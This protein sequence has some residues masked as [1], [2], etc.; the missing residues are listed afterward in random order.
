M[1]PDGNEISYPFPDVCVHELFERQVAR[2]PDAVAIV[3]KQRSLTYG[4][5]NQR[6][7]RVAHFL[8]ARGIGPEILVGVCQERTPELVVALLA[9]WKAGGAY[10]PFD[11]SYPRERLLFM[12][13]DA[14]VEFLLT[15]ETCAKLLPF[16]SDKAVRL[17]SD[18]PLFA[19]EKTSDPGAT[20]KSCNLAYVMYTSGSTGQPK[21]VMILH[22]GLVNYL[23][24]A[25]GAHGVSGSVPVHSSIAF[26]STVAS[27]YPPLLTGGQIELISDD[28][29]VQGLL[30]ALRKEKFRGKLVLTPAH[31]ELLT[32]QLAPNELAGIARALVIAGESLLAEKLSSWKDFAP[33]TRLINEYGPTEATVGCCAYEVQSTDP[34]HGPVP[35]GR[36]I[37]NTQIYLL[38]DNLQQ[39]PRGVAGEMY[40]GGAG[41]AR[42]YWNRPELTKER[43]PDDQF[44]GRA[45][46]RLYKT[47]DLARRL[48]DGTL[49]FIGRV[50]DQVKVRG[51][52]IE[53]GEIEATLARHPGV[54]SCAVVAREDVPGNKQLV[55]YAIATEPGSLTSEDLQ[56]FLGQR[57]P[58]FMVPS[59]FVI[60]D[61]FPVT[62]NGKIERKAL[63]APVY[64]DALP[65]GGLVPPRNEIEEK[66][67]AIWR[68]LLK[69]DRIG[70][71]DDFFDLG[72]H[73]LL[74]IGATARIQKSFGVDLQ[75]QTLFQHP[76]IAKL[77]KMIAETENSDIASTD[78]E[79]K[80]TY[81]LDVQAAGDEPPFFCVGAGVLLRPLSGA[82]GSNQ[83][84]HSIGIEPTAIAK[85]EPPYR[86]EELARHLVS[87][88]RGK[89]PQGPYYLGGFCLDGV[90]AYEIARQ[91]RAQG[92]QVALL[93]LL[94][95]ENPLANFRVRVETGLKRLF[96]R[97]QFRIN[98]FLRTGIHEIPNYFRSRRKEFD[99]FLSR[100]R[101]RLGVRFG[102][103]RSIPEQPDMEKILYLATISYVPA[104]LDCPTVLFRG[105]DWPI[106]SAGDPY[107]G[108][109]ELLA[110]P[111]ET[112]EV[113]G[114]HIGIFSG[115]N[116][117][118]LAC[119]LRDCLQRA[120]LRAASGRPSET[121]ASVA[122]GM[123]V[124]WA[125]HGR[126]M[127][128]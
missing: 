105:E 34:R 41:V 66:L 33:A 91:L 36:P 25:I 45:G 94:E 117:G 98:Q 21:G 93:V 96:I 88:I 68:E 90:F 95:T 58:D 13:R 16:R 76:T 55:A 17:D 27:L 47:G 126:E 12:A 54:Q 35:I 22:S 10:V 115:D 51:Y 38:D 86:I 29:G 124:A 48:P 65:A 116:V 87:T 8:R 59:Y 52:R 26:D 40:I 11:P 106:A 18:W 114:D 19:T 37:A 6:A 77:A 102:V 69:I 74:A 71:H 46:A 107:F 75:L 112:Y 62:E 3:F 53:L 73:S 83:P 9:V 78:L 82:L 122:E 80:F 92:Q 104:P 50:D 57:L 70:I 101:W 113:P 123:G 49:E 79:E 99:Q 125:E 20:V 109:R 120:K 118:V 32:A 7:N 63:P 64:E 97:M 81:V 89:Q 121:G 28:V 61:S 67:A 31:L 4:E 1:R 42:G 85:I 56:L 15:D 43:F 14:S 108:W 72:M 84:F 23:H 44:S 2:D 5:L 103:F 39:V 127:A 30:A 60:L 24:W 111:S 128:G 110:G 119:Q 100:A